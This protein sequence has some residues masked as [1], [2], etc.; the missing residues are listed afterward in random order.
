MAR[1][2]SVKKRS[3]HV[4]CE[5]FE[6]VRN[7]AMGTLDCFL[8]YFLIEHTGEMLSIVIPLDGILNN[9]IF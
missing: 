5:H 2:E 8:R 4:V 7:A 3:I 1:R 6:L 9:M